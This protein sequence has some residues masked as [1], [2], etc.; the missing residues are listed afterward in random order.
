MTKK[1]TRA[2]I[3]REAQAK[4]ETAREHIIR[5]LRDA[6]MLLSALETNTN[7]FPHNELITAE[8]MELRRVAAR[9]IER[10]TIR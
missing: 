4:N 9:F 2:D 8:A 7:Y 3:I 10:Q 1:T 5:K 6:R